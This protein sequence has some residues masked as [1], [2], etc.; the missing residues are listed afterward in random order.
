MPQVAAR[1]LPTLLLPDA[2]NKACM[3]KSHEED[4]ESHPHN[5]EAWNEV[6]PVKR[7]NTHG[8]GKSS[9]PIFVL[10][11]IPS[12][13]LCGR[14]VEVLRKS[15]EELKEARA[16]HKELFEE[17][18]KENRKQYKEKLMS[19]ALT[20]KEEMVK[21]ANEKMAEMFAQYTQTLP[22]PLPSK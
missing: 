17:A 4:V 14:F 20:M 13:S 15:F 18:K 5:Q 9:D 12:A 3:A 6:T 19:H 7:G 16:R 2:G 22:I 11:G 8:A 21:E 10:T 1:A